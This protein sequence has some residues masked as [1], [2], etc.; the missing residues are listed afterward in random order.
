[1]MLDFY[2]YDFVLC[3]VSLNKIIQKNL[4]NHNFLAYNFLA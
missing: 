4:I 1:M 3:F 2:C